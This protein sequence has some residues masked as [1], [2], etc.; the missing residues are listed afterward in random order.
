MEDRSGNG[1]PGM[2][3]Q[4]DQDISAREVSNAIPKVLEMWR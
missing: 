2:E 1:T 3:Q 4:S